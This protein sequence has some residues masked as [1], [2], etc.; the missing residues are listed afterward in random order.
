MPE[1]YVGEIRLFPYP[2]AP[3]GWAEC[4]GQ[5]LAINTN[6]ALFSLL[7]TAYGGDGTT[8]F[9]LPDLRGRVPMHSGNGQTRLGAAAGVEHVAL[10]PTNLPLHTHAAN[11]T[12]AVAD[13]SQFAGN[14]IAQCTDDAE[15][16]GTAV[17]LQGLNPASVSETG[18]S[19][20]HDNCQPSLVTTFCIALQGIFPSRN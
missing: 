13:A 10:A 1:P 3:K 20:A 14:M 4:A 7:G 6:Q 9:A 17:E 18:G 19:Q 15:F 5:L 8:Q 11:G 12:T 2:W 16:Y